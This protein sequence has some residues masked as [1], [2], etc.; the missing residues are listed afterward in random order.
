MVTPAEE[1]HSEYHGKWSQPGV[2]HKGWT[3]VEIYDRDD[4]LQACEMCE[5]A[6]VRYAHV[7][8][9]ELYPERIE[10]GCICA[11]R[12]SEDPV[13]A[14]Q[15]ETNFKNRAKRRAKWLN[16]AGWKS[17]KSNNPRIKVDGY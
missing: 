6:M 4:D 9:H 17:S 2:P 16:R 1:R 7:M 8:S 5:S 11:G 10:V 3:C 13:G 15:R 14:E 12:M